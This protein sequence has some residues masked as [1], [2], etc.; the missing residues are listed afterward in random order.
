MTRLTLEIKSDRDLAILTSFLKLLNVK[1]LRQEREERPSAVEP[2][3]FYRGIAVD[4]SNYKFNRDE[5][6]ER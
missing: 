5:A 2:E 6:N 3:Q 1:V 4:L